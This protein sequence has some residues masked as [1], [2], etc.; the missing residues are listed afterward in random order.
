MK[1]SR[2]VYKRNKGSFWSEQCVIP[3]ESAF[4]RVKLL[5][6]ACVYVCL[7]LSLFHN[8]CLGFSSKGVVKNAK[9]ML[10][11]AS[12]LEEFIIFDAD[13]R[14]RLKHMLFVTWL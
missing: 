4:F 10:Q 11:Y 7:L 2:V 8:S 6:R 13:Q 12:P 14:L 5:L 1:C 9:D 3:R